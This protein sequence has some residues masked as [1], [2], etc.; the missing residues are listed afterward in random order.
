VAHI[1]VTEDDEP[2]RGTLKVML[3]SGGHIVTLAVNG[4]EEGDM[5]SAETWHR[6]LNAIERLQA[7]APSG[8]RW[9]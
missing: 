3:E 5:A 2:V 7:R 9:H 1:L 8:E 6:I 4:D